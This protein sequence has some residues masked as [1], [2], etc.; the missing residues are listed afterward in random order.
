MIQKKFSKKH[1][2]LG[3]SAAVIVIF[4]L[5]FYIWHQTES[6]RLGYE[7]RELEYQT[8]IL[9]KDINKLETIKASYLALE[10]VEKI[11]KEQLKLSPP[12]K[13][14]IIYDDLQTTPRKKMP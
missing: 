12:R 13:N 1:I 9:Q 5:S 4:S 6:I 7:V 3:I 10:K 11:A 2:T 8:H 14:Q